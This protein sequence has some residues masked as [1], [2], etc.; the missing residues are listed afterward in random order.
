MLPVKLLI[1]FRFRFKPDQFQQ[2]QL[3]QD[4]EF[5]IAIPDGFQILQVHVEDDDGNDATQKFLI[6]E[7]SSQQCLLNPEP[8]STVSTSN[9]PSTTPQSTPSTTQAA[10][11]TQTRAPVTTTTTPRPSSTTPSSCSNTPQTPS[12]TSS[13]ASTLS[14]EVPAASSQPSSVSTVFTSTASNTSATTASSS[15]E[16]GSRNRKGLLGVILGGVLGGILL[17]VLFF[18]GFLL[19]RRRVKREKRLEKI[20]PFN[21]SDDD[22]IDL[23]GRVSQVTTASGS[24]IYGLGKDSNSTKDSD[25]TSNF[26]G[27]EDLD[28]NRATIVSRSLSVDPRM[29]DS[30]IPEAGSR[31]S[32]LKF[33]KKSAMPVGSK[34]TLPDVPTE[35]SANV[36]SRFQESE[37]AQSNQQHRNASGPYDAYFAESSSGRRSRDAPL[38]QGQYNDQ[39]DRMLLALAERMEGLQAKIDFLMAENAGSGRLPPPA[40]A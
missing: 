10:Q 23:S 20:D 19:L 1:V 14:S 17:I 22:E 24:P 36:F 16:S 7:A 25:V 9:T 30:L 15:T 3:S 28:T 26:S 21:P 12:L 35:P 39:M 40:Y 34:K 6:A 2:N 8:S 32:S 18:L 27:L 33:G 31:L 37:N 5:T 38:L 13:S 11:R 4:P 29:N